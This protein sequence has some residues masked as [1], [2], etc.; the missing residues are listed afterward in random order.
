MAQGQRLDRIEAALEKMT[1]RQDRAAERQDRTDAQI[2]LMAE[3]SRAFQTAVGGAIMA[4]QEQIAEN[5]RQ[6]AELAAITRENT[7]NWEQLRREWEA[8]LRRFPQS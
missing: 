3:E 8:Y 1:E 7:R 4:Q 6:I 5:S 2:A